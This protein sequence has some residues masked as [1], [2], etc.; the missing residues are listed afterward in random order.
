[1]NLSTASYY[2]K[3]IK[4]INESNDDQKI[5]E[6]IQALNKVATDESFCGSCDDLSQALSKIRSHI[7]ASTKLI[8]DLKKEN[9][10]L[11]KN[12]RKKR[13]EVHEYHEPIKLEVLKPEDG[14]NDFAHALHNGAFSTI[15]FD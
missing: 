7:K 14:P 11:Q 2:R 6:M 8:R 4:L 12:Q 9:A 1:M 13:R 15:I 5:M 3:L 10:E